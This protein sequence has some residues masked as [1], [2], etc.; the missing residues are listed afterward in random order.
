LNTPNNIVFKDKGSL[1][2]FAAGDVVGKPGRRALSQAIPRLKNAGVDF[3]IVNGENA[4]GGSGI[5]TQIADKIFHYGADV[6]TTGDHFFKNQNILGDLGRFDNLIRPLNFPEGVPGKGYCLVDRDGIGPIAVVNLL[7][8]TFINQGNCPFEAAGKC[9]EKLKDSAKFII[10]DFHA[11]ATSEKLA[12]GY[13]LDGKISLLF[14]T[15]THV[16]TADEK[17]LPQGTGFITDIGMTGAHHSILGRK[18]EPVLKRFVMQIPVRFDIAE[19]DIITDGIIAEIDRASGKAISIQR[20]SIP[21]TA[22]QG[23]E[24]EDVE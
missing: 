19:D 14:G 10:V 9:V 22:Q 11:E 24:K 18:I 1:K 15:H 17:I 13:F 8:R 12:M 21:Y 3:V 20:I 16:P 6:I 5:T 23:E 4:A 7:G 2:V